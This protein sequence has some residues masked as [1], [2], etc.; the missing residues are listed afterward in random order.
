MS[1]GNLV[2]NLMESRHLAGM[3]IRLGKK[4]V[5]DTHAF[6]GN[7]QTDLMNDSVLFQKHHFCL[8][9]PA[10]DFNPAHIHAAG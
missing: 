10:V 4:G 3:R 9:R 2:D 6:Q 7:G 5:K 1:E 8:V